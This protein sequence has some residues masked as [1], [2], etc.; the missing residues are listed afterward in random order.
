[1][2]STYRL[3]LFRYKRY[4]VAAL[5]LFVVG[6]VLGAIAAANY[7]EQIKELL[8]LVAGQ[9]EKLGQD[10]FTGSRLSGT[11]ILFL[12]N[13]RA[14]AMIAVLGLALGIYPTFAMAFNGAIIGI[15]GV[16]T[17][18]QTSW[19]TFMAG[20]LP[21]GILEIPALII[22]AGVGLRLGIGP[23]FA[24]PRSPFIRMDEKDRSWRGYRQELISALQVLAFAAVLLFFAAIIEVNIT[25]LVLAKFQ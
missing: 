23:L 3:P 22:G 8:Q 14:V 10:I 21:H 6:I 9:L 12:H 4:I 11:F 5:V 13:L 1:M 20:I 17:A 16:F 15:F 2:H 24:K 7:A 25:P 19:L 18:Q